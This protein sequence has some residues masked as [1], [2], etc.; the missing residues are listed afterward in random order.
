MITSTGDPGRMPFVPNH[1]PD[2]TRNDQ[3]MT[4]S[5]SLTVRVCLPPV[6]P[7]CTSSLLVLCSD[8]TGR[9]QRSVR[10]SNAVVS[11]VVHHRRLHGPLQASPTTQ[12]DDVHF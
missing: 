10:P 6:K 3:P 4:Q 9:V 11:D 2:P 1:D 12:D 7:P 8:L 5:L